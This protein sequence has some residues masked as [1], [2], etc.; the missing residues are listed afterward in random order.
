MDY[1][2]GVPEPTDYDTNVNFNKSGN[3]FKNNSFVV[4][5]ILAAITLIL[6]IVF[7]VVGDFSSPKYE[8]L[9]N[10]SYLSKLVVSGGVLTPE[11]SKENFEYVVVTNSD[12]VSFECT[13][14]SKKSKVTGCDES[15]EVKD[16]EVLHEIIVE[17]EDTNISKYKITIVR[18]E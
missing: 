3:F 15:I 8:Q 17:A 9:D 12:T 5:L 2:S 13:L 1:Y 16:E 10:D 14:S 11:F 4:L 6:I 18:G 7:F